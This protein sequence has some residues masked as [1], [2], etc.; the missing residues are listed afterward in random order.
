MGLGVSSSGRAIKRIE[1]E[2][3]EGSQKDDQPQKLKQ[4]NI[5]HRLYHQGE[6]MALFR[7]CN[8]K[9]NESVSN[10][11]GIFRNYPRPLKGRKK[12]SQNSSS[13]IHHSP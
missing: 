11:K 1:L 7:G 10:G 8:N 5:E 12:N 13:V 2:F 4:Q 3:G 6:D 9:W